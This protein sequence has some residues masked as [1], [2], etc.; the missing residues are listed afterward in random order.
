MALTAFSLVGLYHLAVLAGT[1]A[2]VLGFGEP[3]D[4][5]Y[6]PIARGTVSIGTIEADVYTSSASRTPIL[7][8]HG[9]NETGKNSPEVR[10]VAEALAGSGFRVVAPEFVRLTRQTVTP[11]DIDDVVSVFRS[12]GGNGGMVCASYGCGP[13]LVAASRP[14][15]RGQVRFIV[16]FGGYSDLTETVRSIV[17]G[18]PSPLGYSKWT[19]MAANSDLLGNERDRQIIGAI[20][21][22]RVKRPA[23]E[24]T[25]PEGLG[26]EA[27]ALLALYESQSGEE[28]DTRLRETPLLR[29]RMERLSPSR[30]FDGLRARLIIIHMISDPCIPFTESLRMAEAAKARGIPH[31]ITILRMYGH[32]RPEWPELGVGSLF[33]YY[34]PESWKF[35]RV[36]HEVLSY[37]E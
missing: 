20:A 11:A 15:I 12:F 36:L 18:P 25:L 29:D 33:S 16:I 30:Y 34:I 8:V 2:K 27:R 14:E 13:T 5:W 23:E 21:D 17:T 26:V 31:S 35:I 24:W 32:T 1:A 9:V 19:Y 7:L 10:R 6:G 28:F 37:A 3:F 4:S 22:E